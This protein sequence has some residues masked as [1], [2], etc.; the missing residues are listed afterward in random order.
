MLETLAQDQKLRWER[1]DRVSVAFY[2]QQYPELKRDL[3]V[4]R[5]L[6]LEEM[7]LRESAG[8]TVRK[9]EYCRDYPECRDAIESYQSMY[10]TVRPNSAELSQSPTEDS[11]ESEDTDRTILLDD[12]PPSM[13]TLPTPSIDEFETVGFSTEASPIATDRTDRTVSRYPAIPGFEILSEL[14]RG[15]MGIVYRAR[16]ISANRI[17]ALKI[18]RNDQLENLPAKERD[19]TIRRFTTEAIATASL[20]HDNL[21]SV[22]EVGEVPNKT[23]GS[24]P[25]HYYAMR[26]VQGDTLFDIVREGP[27]E[28]RRA[29]NYMQKVASALQAAHD[30]GVLH[31]DLKPHNIMIE[32][33]SDRP[34]VTDFGLAKILDNINSMTYSGQVMGTPSYMSPEQAVDAANVTAAADQYSIGATLYHLLTGRPPFVAS[35]APETIRQILDKQPVSLRELNSTIHR[36]LETICLKTIQKDPGKRYASCKDLAEDL[37]RYLE[38][39]PIVAR[40]VGRIARTWRWCR[41][42]PGTATMLGSLA[43]LA[44]ST[45]AAIVVGYRN[46]SA[47]L[48]ISESRLEKALLVVDELFTRVSEDELLNEPGMQPLRRELLEK[49]LKHYEYFLSE[50]GGNEK[51]ADEVAS[52]HY[53]VGMIQQLTG[54]LDL[55]EEELKLARNQQEMLLAQRPDRAGRLKALSDTLNALGSLFNS[56]R[57]PEE[58]VKMFE[59]S[60]ATRRQLAELVSDNLEYQRLACN[61]LM[62]LGVAKIDIGNAEEG[63][64]HISEAQ[65]RRLALLPKQENPSKLRRDLA[66]GWYTLGK[67]KFEQGDVDAAI[68]HFQKAVDE[69]RK[70]L[71]EDARSLSNRF[72]CSVALTQLG[73]AYSE[74]GNEE[75]ATKIYEEASQLTRKLND[76]NPDVTPYK[77]QLA[78]LSMNLGNNYEQNE[79]WGKAEEAWTQ[80]LGLERE[81]L[82]SRSDDADLQADVVTCLGALGDLAIRRGDAKSARAAY[83]EAQPM[84]QALANQDPENDMFQEQLRRIKTQLQDLAP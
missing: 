65:N 35:T 58:S 31:R 13:F 16:Q 38:G 82:A 57:R 76:S 34:L 4:F 51:L 10:S 64:P 60:W 84:L 40:P 81:L 29:A 18:V 69:F 17:V 73:A 71:S 26:L 83:Q 54:N 43:I 48:A 39:V 42:N 27:L 47:A 52:A 1:G 62:N 78:V 49:A 5:T 46:T 24:M 22:Y 25:I 66:R 6:V 20:Q 41:R 55:A 74:R 7:R 21:V 12:A 8:E 44:V 45:M 75:L 36:D 67:L 56:K 14:G 37:Q 77:M 53:R 33:S 32:S 3:G 68:V 50:S 61:S 72:D 23:P 59:Q 70:L 15:G 79:Q 19:V 30:K 11:D 2:L 9:T 63:M 28:N 80:A